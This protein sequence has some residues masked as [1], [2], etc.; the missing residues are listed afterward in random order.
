VITDP[1]EPDSDRSFSFEE[2]RAGGSFERIVTIT[3]QGSADLALQTIAGTDTI[4]G[5]FS[6]VDGADECS[7]QSLEPA[8]S[9]RVRVRFA[10][11]ELG[12]AEETFDISSNDPDEA[13]VVMSISGTAVEAPVAPPTPTPEGAD[14]GFMAIDPATLLLLGGALGYAWR[15]RRAGAA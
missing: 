13:V 6:I 3:N 12:D 5:P 10:P 1:T 9:C 14:S 15:R 8:E 7:G 4:T 2:V 11:T